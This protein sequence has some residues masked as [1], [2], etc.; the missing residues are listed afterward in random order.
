MSEESQRVFLSARLLAKMKAYNSTLKI[1]I[2]NQPF[3]VP[4]G[5]VYGKM[6]ILG[7]KSLNSGKSGEEVLVRRTGILQ[8]TFYSP[9]EEGT[10]IATMAADAVV[11]AFENFRGKDAA[12][13]DY[14]FKA[15][16]T[17]YPDAVNGWTP[18]IV[19]IPYHRD[20][21]KALPENLA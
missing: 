8:V 11:K 21:Y 20:E 2:P 19:R 3:N 9:A 15:A 12:G 5:E 7:G 17:R 6:F 4:E 10:K 13:V 14:T 1:A 16:E 18:T